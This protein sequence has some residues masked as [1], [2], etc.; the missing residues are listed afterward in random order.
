MVARRLALAGPFSGKGM[1]PALYAA[2]SEVNQCGRGVS[3]VVGEWVGGRG[4]EGGGK[5][6]GEWREEGEE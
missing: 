1:K 2:Y 6:A 4:R 5:E 3:W